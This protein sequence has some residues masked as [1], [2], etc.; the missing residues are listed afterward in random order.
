M[1]KSSLPLTQ[2]IPGVFVALLLLT[3][4]V[5][6]E[7]E[8][9]RTFGDA[10]A[11]GKTTVSLRYRF[12]TVDQDGFDREAEA[13]TLRTTLSYGSAPYRGFRVFLEA[14]NVTAVG[15]D[16]G[17][18]N[19][20][21]DSLNNGV[22]DRPV[23]ADPEITE[24]LQAY[25][26]WTGGET[27]LRL[28]RQKIDLGNQRFVGSVGWR[29]HHQSF[30]AVSLVNRTFEKTTL[31]Y[32]YLDRAHR[33]FGDRQDMSSHLLHLEFGLGQDSSLTAYGY[34]LDYED[35]A[36][37]L[38]S[39]WTYGLRWAGKQ[40]LDR[41]RI[42]YAF[43][44]ALQED[45]GDNPRDV[46]ADYFLAELGIGSK[47]L[48]ITAGYEVLSG[49]PEDGAFSTPL[50]TLHKFNGWADKFL[51]TPAQGLVD[52]YGGLGGTQGSFSWKIIYHDFSPEGDGE[53]YGT[54]LDVLATYK[55]RNGLSFGLKAAFYEAEALATDTE[56]IMAWTAYKFSR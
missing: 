29:Q 27:T 53:D 34:L 13:S 37:A 4:P 35:P 55:S 24:I 2:R 26:E 16:D 21:A 18:N 40:A 47:A 33:I 31:G 9:P 30:T 14:E 46:D 39:T 20:G 7:N 25:L 36:D 38:A 19:A 10:L 17:Y 42:S 54:E 12:E 8:I 48:S 23:V 50:A 45:A 11:S 15:D 51:R 52:L 56:K 32:H 3:A 43:E 6:A 49:S 1:K 22:R 28:G 5:Q 44:A 41:T